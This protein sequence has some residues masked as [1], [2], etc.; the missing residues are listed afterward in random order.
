MTTE[1]SY[2]RL[3]YP[4][5][6]FIQTFP[7]RFATN[8]T[9]FGMEPASPSTCRVMELGCGNGSN[10]IAQAYLMPEASFVG[11]DL[12]AV[13][14]EDA[15][16]A[17]A[18]LGLSN[19]EFYQKDVTEM[20][21]ADSGTFDYVTAHGL[22]SWVPQFVRDKVLA[23]FRELLNE[24]GVGYIS[25]SAFPGAYQRQMAQQILRLHTDGITDPDEK[26][27]SALSFL[28]FLAEN[29]SDGGIYRA[30]LMQEVARHETHE[31]GDIFHDDLSD[32]NQAYYFQEF[33]ELLNQAG[34]QFVSEA[35]LHAMGTNGLSPEAQA[36]LADIEDPIDREQYLDLLR[37][38]VFRQTLFCRK[39]LSIASAP[40]PAI[41]DKLLLASSLTPTS[42]DPDL[43]PGT[44]EGFVSN[45]NL[46]MQID[47]PLTKAAIAHLGSIWAKAIPFPELLRAAYDRLA[48]KDVTVDDPEHQEKILRAI[49]LQVA[50]GSTMIALHVHQPDGFTEVTAKPK[51]NRLARW[52][53]QNAS[54]ISTTFGLDMQIQD[55]VSRRLLELLDGSRTRDETFDEI[56]RFVRSADDVEGRAQILETLPEW[57][58]ES[59]LNLAKIGVFEA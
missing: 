57:L 31:A 50:M 29:T 44:I 38:R 52:Q 47:Q 5:K 58:D 51:V 42:E 25:Y 37:G 30:I 4:S 55:D 35:E 1:F 6:F 26:V 2:D 24:N 18:E 11:V 48:D 40:D 23:L 53:M 36:F 15:N 43:G 21:A 56:D 28:E 17:A 34:L 45:N 54:N 33:A 20:S 59:L 3:P 27:E 7:D 9:L 46:G 32:V 19:V 13:H 10:L 22:F 41:F 16:A 12:S 8:A 49:V 39:E 14:I